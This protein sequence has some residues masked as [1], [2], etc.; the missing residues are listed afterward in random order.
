[1][2]HFIDVHTHILP[3]VDDG[4]STLEEAIKM[5][6]IAAKD[7]IGIMV[8][9]PHSLNGVYFNTC[10]DIMKKCEDMNRV[11]NLEQVPVKIIPGS[12]VR[13]CPEVI[14]GLK[15]E[16]IMT[17]N[18]NKKYLNI[19]LTDQFLP[20]TVISFLKS[21]NDMKLTPVISHPERNSI[22]WNDI[23]VL[24]RFIRAGAITQITGGSL[25]GKF[26][27]QSLKCVK[28]M[29]SSSMI[30]LVGSDCHSVKGRKPEL[31]GAYKKLLILLEKEAVDRIFF[32]NPL[33]II[34]SA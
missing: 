25:L 14:Q 5:A 9:T 22:I 23:S 28:K 30:H 31:S 32:A 20:D 4:P 7:G 16:T 27:K 15:D 17:I 21:I 18:D 1:M 33:N 2:N 11:F 19:E 26:G 24:E 12:E 29:A 10:N 8:A 34:E 13:V 6:R 3:G